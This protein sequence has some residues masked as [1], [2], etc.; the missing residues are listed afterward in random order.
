METDYFWGMNWPT[1]TTLQLYNFAGR[2][3]R[4]SIYEGV[5]FTNKI[6]TKIMFTNTSRGIWSIGAQKQPYGTW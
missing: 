5:L 1:V 6:N 4:Y 2:M 3:K